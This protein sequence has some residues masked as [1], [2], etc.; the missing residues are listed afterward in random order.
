MIIQTD[1]YGEIEYEER[2]LITF[3]DGIF[4]FPNLKRYLLLCL[5]EGDDTI[6]LMLSTEQPEIVF[7]IVNPLLFCPDYAPLLSEAELSFLDAEDA[8]ELSYYS[9][10][11]IRGKEE[12]LQSTVNLKCPLVIDPVTRKG[13]QVILSDPAYHYRHRFDSFSVI[14]ESADMEAEEASANAGNT[15]QEE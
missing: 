4:G 6:L 13:M 2:D 11:N 10:C 8:D 12:Y 1:S 15:T 7:A 5:T 14:S 3:P 9:I